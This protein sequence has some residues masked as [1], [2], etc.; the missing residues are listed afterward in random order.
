MGFGR[1]GKRRFL[2]LTCRHTFGKPKLIKGEFSDFIK[3][4]DFVTNKLNKLALQEVV[5]LSHQSIWRKFKPFFRYSPTP[6]DSLFLLEEKKLFDKNHVWVLGIDGKWLHRAGVVMIYRN[7]TD[8][9]NLYWS[10]HVSESYDALTADCKQLLPIVKNNLPSGVIS[11][12]KGVIVGSI[13]GFLPPVPHQRCLSHVQRQLL[14]FLP[15]HSPLSATQAL[16]RMAKIIT[17]INNDE[18]K[19]QWLK[20]VDDWIVNHQFLL[21]ERTVGIGTKKKWWYTHGNLRRAVK[22]LKFDEKHLFT[23]LDYLYLPRTNNSIE[24]V[25]SQIKTKLSNHRAMKTPQQVVY[26]FWLMTF[27]RV[28]NRKDPKRLWDRLKNKIFRFWTH[29]LILKLKM[30]NLS[31]INDNIYRC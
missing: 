1:T 28:K 20:S 12:W 23:Y 9:I 10:W 16:R 15:L 17:Q 8:R 30:Y 2:C 26:I 24:G 13:N 18:E 22:L 29:I 25:N 6:F 21:R 5:F 31:I 27:R 14:T 3:F 19:N 11:D 7:V 4:Y